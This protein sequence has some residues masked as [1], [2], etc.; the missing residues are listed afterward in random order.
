MR[1]PC[2]V[3]ELMVQASRTDSVSDCA[4]KSAHPIISPVLGLIPH[5]TE[6]ANLQHLRAHVLGLLPSLV[7]ALTFPCHSVPREG[8][9]LGIL[10]KLVLMVQ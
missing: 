9:N 2:Y 10:T 3:C 6:H 7:S 4:P 5:Q 1:E 8:R